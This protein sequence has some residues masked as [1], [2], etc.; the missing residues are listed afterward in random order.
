ML[1]I[2]FSSANQ[3]AYNFQNASTYD[4]LKKRHSSTLQ[5]TNNYYQQSFADNNS[6]LIGDGNSDFINIPDSDKHKN[7]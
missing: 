4:S 5:S 3:N 2:Y 1:K 7:L 6:Y